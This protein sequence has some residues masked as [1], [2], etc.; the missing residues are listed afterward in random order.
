MARY[1]VKVDGQEFDITLE[2][3]ADK[4]LATVNGKT[5]DVVVHELGEFRSILLVNH[6]SNEVDVYSDGYDN[7]RIV[8]MRGLEIPAEIE[9]YNLAQLRKTAGIAQEVKVD[10]LL[11]AAMPG[12]VVDVKVQPGDT[13]IKGQA[14]L[15]LG[16]MKMENIIKAPGDAT[17]KAVRV[18]TGKSVEKDDVLLEFA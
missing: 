1:L 18:S 17:I 14:L 2:Y 6:E 4:Y 10:R 15:I 7:Q 3:R 5:V 13:V 11:R 9:E 8:F 12:L 16:A